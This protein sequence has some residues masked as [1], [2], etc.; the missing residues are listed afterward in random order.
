MRPSVSSQCLSTRVSASKRATISV[1]FPLVTS[2]RRDNSVNDGAGDGRATCASRSKRG[3]LTEY[4][5]FKLRRRL[6]KMTLVQLNNRSQTRSSKD[7]LFQKR[8]FF[9]I[10]RY[11]LLTNTVLEF[12][13]IERATAC[14]LSIDLQE[15]L[16][17]SE[18]KI[19]IPKRQLQEL[20]LW[21]G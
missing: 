11:P 1:I 20:C 13:S 5:S 7:P 19:F 10:T 14:A 6:R 3:M 16:N 18:K 9:A 15:T 4:V 21:R 2:S 12:N 17:R 8:V